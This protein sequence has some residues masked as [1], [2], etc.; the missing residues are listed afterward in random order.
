M[1]VLNGK[2]SFPTNE[3]NYS[4][5]LKEI[6]RRCLRVKP[7]ERPNID[8][9]SFLCPWSK[10]RRAFADACDAIRRSFA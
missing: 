6:V 2:Y 8:E 4:E 3:G 7:Q 1:A 10:R 5:G 9:V